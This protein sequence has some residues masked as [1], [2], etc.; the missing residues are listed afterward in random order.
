MSCVS[1]QFFITDILPRPLARAN[2]LSH[3]ITTYSISYL[4]CILRPDGQ[5]RWNSPWGKILFRT[6]RINFIPWSSLNSTFGLTSHLAC[7]AR[8]IIWNRSCGIWKEGV[9]SYLRPAGQEINAGSRLAVSNQGWVRMIP[10][11]FLLFFSSNA[12]TDVFSESRLLLLLLTI[13]STHSSS[14]KSF[15]FSLF[16]REGLWYTSV[17][18]D[19]V[20]SSCAG[21]I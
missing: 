13:I 3:R 18:L 16:C 8:I 11:I 5:G 6:Q 12:L 7:C 1:S 10:R 15:R 20:G 9:C 19:V 2:N 21:K 4:N 17:L 14:T